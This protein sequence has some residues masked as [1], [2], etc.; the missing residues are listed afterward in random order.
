[1]DKL[2]VAVREASELIERDPGAGVD[3]PRPY[4]QLER[5]R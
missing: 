1:V 5:R 4:P 2:L 3:A